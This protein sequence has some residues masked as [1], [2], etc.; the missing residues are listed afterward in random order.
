MLVWYISYLEVPESGRCLTTIFFIFTLDVPLKNFKKI[1]RDSNR[2]GYLNWWCILIMFN[3]EKSKCGA[4]VE[5][6]VHWCLVTRIRD[7]KMTCILW[8]CD[9]VHFFENESNKSK[10]HI[11]RNVRV[12]WFWE[13]LLL[14]STESLLHP[15]TV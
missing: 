7:K 2:M 1:G 15:S 9:I 3:I 11:Q 4:N 8:V 14:Y 10:L 6:N 5:C 12:D 13:C